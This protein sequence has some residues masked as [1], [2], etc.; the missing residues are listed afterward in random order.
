MGFFKKAVQNRKRKL[1]QK[2]KSDGQS[3]KRVKRD[4][5]EILSSEE[6]EGLNDIRHKNLNEDDEEIYED[7]QAKTVRESRR[8]LD[9]LV[10]VFSIDW[11]CSLQF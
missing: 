2:R 11:L 7:I 3:S 6:D 1:G 5:E 10:G 4:D 9:Q 8:V